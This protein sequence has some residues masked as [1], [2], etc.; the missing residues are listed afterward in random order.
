MSSNAPSKAF[1]LKH[2]TA[3]VGTSLTNSRLRQ[4]LRSAAMEERT[5]TLAGSRLADGLIDVFWYPGE[6]VVQAI[7]HI[8]PVLDRLRDEEQVVVVAEDAAYVHHLDPVEGDRH[9]QELGLR[10]WSVAGC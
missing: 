9:L 2:R 5:G 1:L 7:G 3:E 10:A 8:L 4:R 6:C